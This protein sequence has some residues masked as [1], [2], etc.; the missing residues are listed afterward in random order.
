M[1]YGI[2]AKK[3][4]SLCSPLTKPYLGFRLPLFPVTISPD[5]QLPVKQPYDAEHR[6]NHAHSDPNAAK[7]IQ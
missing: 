6:P 1:A 5:C 3:A 2:V 4:R 7:E